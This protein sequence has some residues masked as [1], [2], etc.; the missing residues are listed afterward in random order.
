MAK[1]SIL[2]GLDVHNKTIAV[3]IVEAGRGGLFRIVNSALPPV[4]V[5]LNPLVWS[6]IRNRDF[7]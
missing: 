4:R 7:I 5:Q 2:V 3:A 1:D 6:D